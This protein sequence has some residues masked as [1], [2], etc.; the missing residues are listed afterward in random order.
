ME[1][2]AEKVEE[3]YA[4]GYRQQYSDL[5]NM[6]N[7]IEEESDA[8]FDGQ[9]LCVNLEEL[10]EYIRTEKDGSGNKKYSTEAFLGITK[11]AD[12]IGLEVQRSRDYEGVSFL[13]RRTQL[14]AK[15]DIDAYS[16]QL[17]ESKGE[18]ERMRDEVQKVKMELVAILSIFAA[19]VIA[20]SG[21]LNYLGGTLSGAGTADIYDVAFAVLLCGILMFNIIAF[22]MYMVIAIVRLHDQED[23]IEGGWWHRNI[24]RYTGSHF[25]VGFNLVVIA[26]MVIV[27]IFRYFS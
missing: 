19:I 16:K 15:S 5:L 8:H 2:L 9:I 10:S 17:D 7:A 6:L 23:S 24:F 20:F 26:L 13:L 18:L 22:L 3:I 4:N 1:S 14:E 25:I 21:G 12:H 11:L 27:L